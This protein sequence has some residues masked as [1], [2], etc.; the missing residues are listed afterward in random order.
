ML[1]LY[2]SA[3]GQVFH[4]PIKEYTVKDGL[5]QSQVRH[6]HPD[7]RGFL[8]V[9][10]QSG[11]SIFDGYTFHAHLF[12]DLKEEYVIQVS[13]SPSSL[14]FNGLDKAKIWDGRLRE[15][16]ISD[17]VVLSDVL[18]LCDC[19][20]SNFCF[21][22]DY[23]MSRPGLSS[24]FF[25]FRDTLH[26]IKDLSP[27]LADLKYFEIIANEQSDTIQLVD[28]DRRLL[29]FDLKNRK[30]F[31]ID[32][33]TFASSTFFSIKESSPAFIYTED[34]DSS[35]A[36]YQLSYHSCTPVAF[37]QKND[38]AY[39]SASEATAPMIVSGRYGADLFLRKKGGYQYDS[40]INHYSV[41]TAAQFLSNQLIG[42]DQGIKEITFNGLSA[43]TKGLWEYPWNVSRWKEDY[44]CISTYRN[45]LQIVDRNGKMI[46]K[47]PYP[48]FRSPLP[49]HK[50][51][52][53]IPE[54]LSNHLE[55]PHWKLWGSWH[56]FL[57]YNR[58]AESLKHVPMPSI[59]E[60]FEYAPESDILYIAGKSLF[61]YTE[62]NLE[63]TK[64]ISLPEEIRL[65]AEVTD[66][67]LAK[68]GGLWLSGRG[69]IAYLPRDSE[70]FQ[71]FNLANQKFPYQGAI[72]LEKDP[73]GR[74]WVGGTNGLVRC[75]GNQFVKIFPNWIE[76][77]INQLLIT[78]D[79]IGLAVSPQNIYLFR[80]AKDK[81]S[82]IR[83]YNQYSGYEPTEPSENG[84][85]YD[86]AYHEIW[87]PT[88]Q[89]VLKIDL[90]EALQHSTENARISLI[91]VNGKYLDKHQ[92][93]EFEIEGE[94]ASLT[95]AKVDPMKRTWD[96][97][98]Q[99]NGKDIS[100]AFRQSRFMVSG[101]K[102]GENELI[103]ISKPT[104]NSQ[105]PE[106]QKYVLLARLPLWDRSWFLWSLAGTIAS[107][108]ALILWNVW[109]Q[110]AKDRKLKALEL[111]LDL[112]RL[113]TL[114]AY[115]NPHFIFNTLTTIQDNILQR[116]RELGNELIVRLSR[117]FRYAL[118]IDPKEMESGQSAKRLQGVPLEQEIALV[119]D[120]IYLQQAQENSHVQYVES[121]DPGLLE[122]KIFIPKLLIQPFVEN[123]FKHAFPKNKDEDRLRLHIER[124]GHQLLIEISDNGWGIHVN[125]KKRRASL[126]KKLAL[127]RMEILRSL[128]IPNN[129]HIEHS[130]MGT[131]IQI[132]IH[133]ESYHH[134]RQSFRH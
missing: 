124:K 122:G 98:Y 34:E 25:S 46:Q 4:S 95:I 115:F 102:H 37:R 75:D 22:L 39:T 121:I 12:Q 108:L 9:G 36:V 131:V 71:V 17:E 43:S 19:T 109:R 110:R 18:T 29:F 41:R 123:I 67:E 28:K 51:I 97:H 93:S 49:P 99:L 65:R 92:L 128:G 8:W 106:I 26:D 55:T 80:V 119:R 16:V 91:G 64:E 45:G 134:R 47:I 52:P 53:K 57:A 120:Y 118:R 78:P 59:I 21:F 15:I 117:I 126:G 100:P 31:R 3:N 63:L 107:L 27:Q 48:P 50:V 74:L 113:R 114:E 127:E 54:A 104:D 125:N 72:S 23:S 81:C 11:I 103:L 70:K 40:L 116:N 111:E 112:N 76:G 13:K 83:S 33:T 94:F 30:L 61:L 89:N 132:Y 86:S 130:E 90:K 69:G 58:A 32:S 5:P 87:I 14:V 2:P 79:G 133:Y 85:F 96:H 88:V 73:W 38:A 77:N 101:L 10:T 42:T 62:S 20:Q 60:A 82:P 84:I 1:G 44:Y 105:A 24:A 7:R 68:D 129:I 6:L 66:L 35:S 56:G